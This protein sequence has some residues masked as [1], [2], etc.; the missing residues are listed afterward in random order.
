MSHPWTCSVQYLHNP[1]LFWHVHQ[2]WNLVHELTAWKQQSK[3]PVKQ[4]KGGN[5]TGDGLW[6]IKKEQNCQILSSQ[7]TFAVMHKICGHSFVLSKVFPCI[8][9]MQSFWW[10]CFNSHHQHKC[11]LCTKMNHPA[12]SPSQPFSP[13][14]NNDGFPLMSNL[15]IK[16][17]LKLSSWWK[18]ISSR[19]PWN[20]S[21]T[22]LSS[23]QV[24]CIK[25]A[26]LNGRDCLTFQ[27]SRQILE[28][29]IVSPTFSFLSEFFGLGW[30][31]SVESVVRRAV[32]LVTRLFC[33]MLI[34]SSS[35]LSYRGW[36]L[37]E[38]IWFS[39]CR[40]QYPLEIQH[41]S[42]WDDRFFFKIP[43]C[44]DFHFFLVIWSENRR[45]KCLFWCVK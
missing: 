20:G 31:T 41:R 45:N 11:V 29:K 3:E 36:S 25:M 8:H 26:S 23:L 37:G 10:M 38:S 22:W 17:N 13:S 6:E 19:V 44:S 5:E 28:E 2:F 35:R 40:W 21:N 15:H 32:T 43:K 18:C 33:L 4:W 24:E 12:Q 14:H 27:L 42:S 7:L 16:V 1:L 30:V 34:T 9:K 39:D